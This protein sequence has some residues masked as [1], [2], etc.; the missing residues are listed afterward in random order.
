M[1]RLWVCGF[2]LNSTTSEI[3]THNVG[4]HTASTISS[5]QAHGG[6][7]SSKFNTTSSASIDLYTF[8]TGTSVAYARVWIFATAYPSANDVF[9][10][11]GSGTDNIGNVFMNT[12]GKVGLQNGTTNSF[13]TNLSAV[14]SLNTWHY[15][16]L[17]LTTTGTNAQTSNLY[18]DGTFIDTQNMTETL[19]TTGITSIQWGAYITASSPGSISSFYMDDLAVN[20]STGTVQ[21]S[22]IGNSTLIRATPNGTGDTNTWSAGAGG[23]AGAGN[24]YTR[25]DE[26]TPDSLTSYNESKTL[27]NSDLYIVSVPTI[28]TGSTINAVL[29]GSWYRGAASS[30]NSTF[31]V[32]IEKTSGGTIFQGTAVAPGNTTWGQNQ[33]TTSNY[34]L[35]LYADPDSSA[36]TPATISTMQVGMVTSTASTNFAE[37]STVWAYVD[38]TPGL[39]PSHIGGSTLMTMGVG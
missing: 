29:V 37:V 10:T 39:P 6:T 4:S 35:V 23:T 24:N 1:A 22:F 14:L 25:V 8:S 12:S 20:D 3:T 15:I 26:V 21:N 31:K 33:N 30:A 17:E 38:Y 32:Q 5:T 11:L 34:A 16:D 2:E 18:V 13:G 36:W 28:P 7:F 19:S 27:S 9:L